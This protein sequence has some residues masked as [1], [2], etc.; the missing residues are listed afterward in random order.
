LKAV[1]TLSLAAIAAIIFTGCGDSETATTQKVDWSN[2]KSMIIKASQDIKSGDGLRNEIDL[3]PMLLQKAAGLKS[4][5]T[6]KTKFNCLVSP[7]KIGDVVLGI[8]SATG[9]GVSTSSTRL[10]MINAYASQD[11]SIGEQNSIGGLN[12]SALRDTMNCEL[13]AGAVISET[14]LHLTKWA[15]NKKVLTQSELDKEAT[16][17]MEVIAKETP[18]DFNPI[19]SQ[20]F[21]PAAAQINQPCRFISSTNQFACGFDILSLASGNFAEMKFGQIQLFGANAYGI[22]SKLSVTFDSSIN[23]SRENTMEKSHSNSIDNTNAN[24]INTTVKE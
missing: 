21:E 5:D 19:I 24:K 9:N 16:A 13:N 14:A 6:N 22:S 7:L 17:Y 12:V 1:L 3:Y 23:A 18:K 11:G 15:Q 2:K 4:T 10:E 20:V 8:V